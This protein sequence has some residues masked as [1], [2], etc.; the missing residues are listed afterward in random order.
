MTCPERRSRRSAHRDTSASGQIAADGAY[1]ICGWHRRSGWSLAVSRGPSSSPAG[2]PPRCTCSPARRGRRHRR[3]TLRQA[4]PAWPATPARARSR[5][6]NRWATG[7]EH[8]L[9]QP[10]REDPR[11]RAR[12][13]QSH[14]APAIVT[15]LRP[16]LRA[17]EVAATA[18]GVAATATAAVVRVPTELA[19]GVAAATAAGR[20]VLHRRSPRRAEL[21]VRSGNA[22]W[23]LSG[24]PVDTKK[25][26]AGRGLRPNPQ[27]Q[28]PALAGNNGHRQDNGQGGHLRTV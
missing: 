13:P 5:A 8:S 9:R 25:R 19:A 4:P 1:E 28:P 27:P 20:E 23:R 2:P 22:P 3:A 24:L 12:R 11:A 7:A 6:H 15:D 10:R 26:Q 16:R 17:T 14:L 21:G 18:V